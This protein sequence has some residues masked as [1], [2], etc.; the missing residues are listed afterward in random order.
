MAKIMLLYVE[1]VKLKSKKMNFHQFHKNARIL[2]KHNKNQLKIITLDG[3]RPSKLL[4]VIAVPSA[5]TRLPVAQTGSIS[6]DIGV[7]T[8]TIVVRIVV[9]IVITAHCFNFQ[10]Q[11]L[12]RKKSI[13]F[14]KKML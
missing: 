6:V 12:S 7:V 8:A 4:A 2:N 1:S 5:C 11:N 9:A 10:T 13:R 14:L 3:S